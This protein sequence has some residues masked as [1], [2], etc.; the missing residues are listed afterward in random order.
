MYSCAG[1]LCC[2]AGGVGGVCRRDADLWS[3]GVSGM[4]D[5]DV[6]EQKLTRD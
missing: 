5:W 2:L 6:Q 4:I 1:I 3:D